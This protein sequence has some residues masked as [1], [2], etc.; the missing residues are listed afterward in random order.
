MG[1]GVS[2]GLGFEGLGFVFSE[3]RGS[4]FKSSEVRV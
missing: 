2:S 3:Y 4:G 1:S